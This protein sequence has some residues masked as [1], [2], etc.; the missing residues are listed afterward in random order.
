MASLY[1]SR[2]ANLVRS[3]TAIGR[4]A[5]SAYCSPLALGVLEITTRISMLSPSAAIRSIRFLSDRP[6]PDIS[7]ATGS[8]L[9]LTT[10]APV[11]R[12]PVL[13]IGTP[14]LVG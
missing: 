11:T 2:V 12:N 9:W 13:P 7:T 14:V 3:M 1:A 4:L 5:F 8:G 10:K 6:V